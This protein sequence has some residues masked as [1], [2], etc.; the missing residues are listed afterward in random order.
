L[1]G[2]AAIAAGAARAA[3][4]CGAAVAHGAGAR[5]KPYAAPQIA[6]Q[7]P[8]KARSTPQG[9]PDDVIRPASYGGTSRAE[10][11]RKGGASDHK[12]KDALK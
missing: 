4:R 9:G 7:A 5:V 12:K 11:R 1:V 10:V 3:A 2:E 6:H 8:Q